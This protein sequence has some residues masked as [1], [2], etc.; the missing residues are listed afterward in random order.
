VV[1]VDLQAY[2]PCIFLESA[3]NLLPEKVSY[4]F[5]GQP[6]ILTLLWKFSIF[7]VD[8]RVEDLKILKS[9]RTKVGCD[10][11]M[12]LLRPQGF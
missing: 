7:K 10:N 5:L 3:S 6:K 12:Q 8:A 9:C 4:H 11:H 1:K 2:K